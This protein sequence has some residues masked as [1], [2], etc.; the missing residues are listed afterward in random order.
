MKLQL[1]VYDLSLPGAVE[2]L[3][4]AVGEATARGVMRG[5]REGLFLVAGRN[6]VFSHAGWAPESTV[7]EALEAALTEVS[8]RKGRGGLSFSHH[9]GPNLDAKFKALLSEHCRQ[10][11]AGVV[12]TR[13]H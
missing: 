6:D 2:K 11:T 9:V 7:L 10:H 5:T 3:V 13:S 12:S 1:F 4:K 8:A